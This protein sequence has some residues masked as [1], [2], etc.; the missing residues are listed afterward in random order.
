ML[1]RAGKVCSLKLAPNGSA[2]SPLFSTLSFFQL[3]KYL[4]QLGDCPGTFLFLA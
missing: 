1:D 4:Q 2:A 3:C